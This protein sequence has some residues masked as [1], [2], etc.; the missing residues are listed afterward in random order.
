MRFG[1]R[2]TNDTGQVLTQFSLAYDGEQWLDQASSDGPD[3]LV[4]TYLIGSSPAITDAGFFGVPGLDFVAPNDNPTDRVELDGNAAANRVH[5]SDTV[6]GLTWN[7]G[8]EL[9]LRW[10]NGRQF[11]GSPIDEA[12]GMDDLAF[13]AAVPEPASLT[14]LALG[15]TALAARRRRER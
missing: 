13:S 3:R 10:T 11:Q 7:P 12:I 8:E 5:I 15:A 14:L 1:V 4:F 6:T 9:F 2:F